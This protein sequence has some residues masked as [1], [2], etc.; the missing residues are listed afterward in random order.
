[1]ENKTKDLYVMMKLVKRVPK[2]KF[3][4]N[5]F[6]NLEHGGGTIKRKNAYTMVF[7]LCVMFSILPF[8]AAE[9]QN[10]EK[11]NLNQ[12]TGMMNGIGSNLKI[13]AEEYQISEIQELL[14]N[15]S[16][17]TV[18]EDINALKLKKSTDQ[19]VTNTKAVDTQTVEKTT[20]TTSKVE[21]TTS[22]MKKPTTI[23]GWF[24]PTGAFDSGYEYGWYYVTW[25]NYD[26]SSGCWG[27]LRYNPKGA[28]GGELTSSVTGVDFDGVS[29]Y[30]KEYNPRW[31]LK[32]A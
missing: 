12:K 7:V 29:G 20:S 1:L 31:R 15:H 28:D 10:I 18:S 3:Y 9:P 23:S 14:K 32:R 8:A 13:G 11:N 24:M 17:Y 2:K 27:V 4:K 16:Y 5:F 21:K 25:L 22:C 6:R 30:E 19:T 26:P